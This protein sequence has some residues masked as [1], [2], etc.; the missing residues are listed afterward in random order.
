M[1]NQNI[2]EDC[3]CKI[4]YLPT[5][6]NVLIPINFESLTY[7]DLQQLKKNRLVYYREDEHVAH[8]STC[9]K[10]LA[11]YNEDLIHD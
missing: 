10:L 4:I 8:V 9:N 2:C 7:D 3:G 11:I 6:V 1:Y 5:K